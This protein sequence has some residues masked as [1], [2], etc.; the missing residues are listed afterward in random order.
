M[1]KTKAN[2][3]C[4]NS[5]FTISTANEN[6]KLTLDYRPVLQVETSTFLGATLDLQL[7]WKTHIK[8]AEK[9]VYKELSL[10]K[11]LAGT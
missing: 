11:K 6:V 5:L 2:K 9:R 3:N 1:E 7:L 4:I 10:M 8:T